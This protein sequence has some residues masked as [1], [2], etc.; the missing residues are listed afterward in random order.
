MIVLRKALSRRTM[1]RGVGTM[2]ALPFMEAMMP[3]ARAADITARPKRLQVFYSPN[4][5]MMESFI[6]P[7]RAPARS[8]SRGH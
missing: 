8:C 3:S 2:I 6:G 1:L 5:M 7:P 4:G